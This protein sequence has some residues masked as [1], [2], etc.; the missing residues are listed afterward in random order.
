MRLQ[1]T[2]YKGWNILYNGD[3]VLLEL[4]DQVVDRKNDL[5]HFH[6]IKNNRRSLVYRLE[7]NGLSAILKNPREKNRKKWIRFTTLYRQGEAFRALLNLAS[8]SKSGIAS[9][10]PLLAAEKR[11]FG[12]V[13]DSWIL[14]TY[15]NGRACR[16]TD[17]PAVVETLEEM[18]TKSRLHGDPQI[19][20]FLI[21]GNRVITIDSNPK[22]PLFAS[23]AKY[24]EFFH[25]Q[26]SAPGIEKHFSLD[27]NTAAYAAAAVW[28]K[29]YW[30]WRDLKK[31][32]RIN[33]KNLKRILVIRFSSIGD[34]ILTTPVLTALKKRY[35]QA[36]IDFLVIDSFKDAIT[37]NPLIDDV[38]LFNK[39]SYRGI[40]G[41]YR[42]SRMLQKKNYDL[43]IDLHSKIRSRL[44]TLFT[45]V[46]T[47]RYKKRSLWKSLLVRMR[48]VRY[49]VDDTIVRNYFK[50]LEKLHVYYTG[51][52]LSFDF[53]PE[54]LEKVA[55]YGKAVVMA[56]GAANMTKQWLPEYFAS[57]GR[58]LR[59]KII[60]IGGSNDYDMCED[61]RADIGDS[62]TNLAG[63]LS[64]K[65]SGALMS[66]S[67]YV[68]TNDS[69]PFHIARGIGKKVFVLFGPTDPNMFT[70]DEKSILI[71]GA[72]P[73]APCSLHGDK[74][75]P[76]GHFDCMRS[77][78]PER[79]YQI[80][81]EAHSH[82]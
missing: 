11:R 52:T 10:K 2:T 49:H 44:L 73:C 51:E 50:P 9:N 37:G 23:I 78:T 79:V 18:H 7:F 67:K 56:P 1:T 33:K 20:N 27:T 59:D 46:R 43:V 19:D 76:K 24:R 4:F 45:G 68:I 31:N 40:Y 63:K 62:C 69:G 71:Y 34:I 42:Y 48:V 39:K 81:I 3:S 41:I 8:L 75:C 30:K 12:M 21:Q 66:L 80:I 54:D 35:P 5:R 70:Y 47:L 13:V 58:L 55:H 57:L 64:L 14:Y 53:S 32:R 17:Y 60:L 29:I 26:K 65:Q 6:E 77:L 74:Q 15:E 36:S 28:S 38:I 61:I 22:T 25:L 72:E 82:V 16:E